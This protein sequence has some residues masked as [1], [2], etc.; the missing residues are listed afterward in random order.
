MMVP[1]LFVEVVLGLKGDEVQKPEKR[2]WSKSGE[3]LS[4]Q[5]RPRY[6]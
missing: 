4:G 3:V 5:D 6:W 1:T 2:P